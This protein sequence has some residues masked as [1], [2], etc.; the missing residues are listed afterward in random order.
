M[1]SLEGISLRIGD[2]GQP[3]LSDVSATFSQGEFIAVIGPSGCG[4][5]TL[6]KVIAGIASGKEEGTIRW[7]GRNLSEEDFK[8]SEI[9]YV[10]QFSIAHEELTV[11]ECVEYS[12]RLRVAG[13]SRE[14]RESLVT[15]LLAEVGMAEFSERRVK[16][17]SGGQKRRLALAMELVSRPRSFSAMR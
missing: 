13:L 16:V 12:A 14:E 6:L 8:P 11:E 17:L 4:K 15:R 7:D 9:G 10:P 3:L 2:S 1:L 5:S